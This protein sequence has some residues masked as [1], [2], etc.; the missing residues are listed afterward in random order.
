M[1]LHDEVYYYLSQKSK[2]IA[3]AFRHQ[4]RPP[5]VHPRSRLAIINLNRFWHLH[6][7]SV[8]GVDTVEIRGYLNDD[9]S[10]DQ[11]LLDFVQYVI[12]FIITHQLLIDHGFY[13]DRPPWKE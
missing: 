11:W 12:P 8:S 10:R 4:Y 13:D 7:G 1:A 6:I 2:P 5:D 3:E 9:A